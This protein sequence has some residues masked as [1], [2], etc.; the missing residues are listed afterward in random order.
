MV[1]LKNDVI[2]YFHCAIGAGETIITFGF[3][4]KHKIICPEVA[5]K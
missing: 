5:G 3:L 2:A 1:L 4:I